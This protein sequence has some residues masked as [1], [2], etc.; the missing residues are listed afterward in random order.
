MR[1]SHREKVAADLDLLP[2]DG[3]YAPGHI[4]HADPS[5]PEVQGGLAGPVAAVK[6]QQ[7]KERLRE[8][9]GITRVFSSLR[10]LSTKSKVRKQ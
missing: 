3:L 7:R 6:S 1:G 9:P 8:R 5:D 4:L 10:G 2:Q